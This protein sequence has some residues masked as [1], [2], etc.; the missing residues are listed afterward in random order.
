MS[1]KTIAFV[2]LVPESAQLARARRLCTSRWLGAFVA[3]CALVG[4]PGLYIG[5]NA[6]LSDP[7]INAQIEQVST[8]LSS[9]QAAIPLLQKKLSNL[10]EKQQVLELVKNRIDWREVFAHFVEASGDRVRFTALSATGGGV[11]GTEP[12]NLRVEG[13]APSQTD[14]RA[15]VVAIESLKLFD[16]IELTRTARRDFDDQ[17]VIEFQI[18]ARVGVTP[19]ETGATP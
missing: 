9:N 12:I 17:E 13:I 7:S 14:A 2:N 4:L 5:G 15:Y 11:E 6:A 10:Q 19:N 18:I 16:S 3:T 1:S 8:Q